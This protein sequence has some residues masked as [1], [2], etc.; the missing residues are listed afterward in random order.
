MRFPG[1]RVPGTVKDLSP[2]LL[3]EVML[4]A[5]SGTPGVGKTEC[6]RIMKSRKYRVIDLNLYAE[7]QGFTSGYDDERDSKI[8][9]VEALDEF[10]REHLEEGDM[11]FE[12]HLSHL[13]TVDIA[14]ILRC[15]PPVLKDRLK[16]KGWNERKIMENV[17][18]EIL[19]VI[20]IEAYENLDTV[21]EIDTTCITPLE[22]SDAFQEAITG[23]Y[24]TVDISW[25]D[26]F[27]YM[28]LE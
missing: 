18:A 5:L 7:E 20:K 16:N 2:Y 17:Q 8:I 10:I 3:T 12:G 23:N 25:I 24:R 9:D 1:F 4:I 27:D 26:D 21:I 14:V 6:A 19:D 13:L 11:I 15:S 28:L 22:V